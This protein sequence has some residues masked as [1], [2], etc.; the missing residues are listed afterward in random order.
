MTIET[1]T[2]SRRIK[3]AAESLKNFAT[4][5]T[6]D[7]GFTMAQSQ[8]EVELISN[9][10]N[11]LEIPLKPENLTKAAFATYSRI[12]ATKTLNRIARNNLYPT[13]EAAIRHASIVASR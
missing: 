4:F 3:F 11:K 7:H 9:A 12:G 13:F 6:R 8:K 2:G 10:L 5:L 1:I